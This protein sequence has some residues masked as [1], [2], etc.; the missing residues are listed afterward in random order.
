MQKPI[1]PDQTKRPASVPIKSG[2]RR[3][4]GKKKRFDLIIEEAEKTGKLKA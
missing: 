2:L 1:K 3:G 4:K